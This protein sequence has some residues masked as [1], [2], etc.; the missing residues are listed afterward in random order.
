M[1]SGD[2]RELYKVLD[3]N[4]SGKRVPKLAH[5]V[6]AGQWEAIFVERRVQAEIRRLKA[7]GEHPHGGF[8]AGALD[9]VAERGRWKSG[10]ALQRWLSR[11]RPNRGTKS[12]AP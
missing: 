5:A 8:R 12:R 7:A 9:A 10:E 6:G 2:Q 3:R 1:D 4:W 11:N